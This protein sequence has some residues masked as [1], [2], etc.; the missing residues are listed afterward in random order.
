MFF[1]I[2]LLLQIKMDQLY[3][4]PHFERRYQKQQRRSVRLG[5]RTP[6]FH[7]GNRG[8][9]P[10]RTTQ[11]RARVSVRAKGETL[12]LALFYLR[13]HAGAHTSSFF[14]GHCPFLSFYCSTLKFDVYKKAKIF[15]SGIREFTKSTKLGNARSDQPWGAAFGHVFLHVSR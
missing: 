13:S 7:S 11:S 9:I 5:V 10:L 3:L 6:D 4:H 2:S 15:N 12:D 8:S 1:F 14:I